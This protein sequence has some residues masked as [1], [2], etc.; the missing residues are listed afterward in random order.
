MDYLFVV[1]IGLVIGSFLNVC[2]YR[3]PAEE[4][5][6]FPPSH[7]GNCKHKLGVLDL[8]P[9]FSYLF[10][11]GKCRYCHQKISIQYPLIEILNA[12]LYA[13]VYYKFGATFSFIKYAVF[14]SSMI[15][16]GMIDGKTKFVY[17][18]TTIFAAAAGVVFMIIEGMLFKEKI[19]TYIIGAAFCFLIILL[20][21]VLTK[22]MGEGDIEI[23]IIC[24]L[25][26]GFKLSALGLFLS[27][28][29]GGIVGVILLLRRKKGFKDEMPF[30][31]CLAIGA[32]ISLFAGTN[33][34]SWYFSFWA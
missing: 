20:I 15:V 27:F 28:I 22:G 33:M 29:V 6:A 9:V 14:I 4:S 11:G 34:L 30:G 5:I 23:A 7:C 26:L 31:P 2:I 8:V 25:F 12:A 32:I 1:I 10:L 16:I 17:K 24:G 21:V 18:S 19:L 3:I 13:A